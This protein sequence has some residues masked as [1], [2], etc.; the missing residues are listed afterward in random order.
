MG[1]QV[2]LLPHLIP[3]DCFYAWKKSG[4]SIQHVLYLKQTNKKPVVVCSKTDLEKETL[5]QQTRESSGIIP[6]WDASV[7][8]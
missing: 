5:S 7:W 1:M 6:C 2:M 3:L 4:S 8:T